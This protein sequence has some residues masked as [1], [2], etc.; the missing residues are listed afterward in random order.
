MAA[1]TA[2]FERVCKVR[3][4]LKI[5]ENAKKFYFSKVRESCATLR[6]IALEAGMYKL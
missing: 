1:T 6:D 2:A 4:K 3:E 5:L